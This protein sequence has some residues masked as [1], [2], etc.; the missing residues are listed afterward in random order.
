MAMP[1]R[2]SRVSGVPGVLGSVAASLS[3]VMT[4]EKPRAASRERSLKAKVRVTSFSTMDSLMR[5]PLSRPPWAGSSRMTVRLKG[6]GGAGLG[7]GCA[8]A[9]LP[10][11]GAAG[12]GAGLVWAGL[13]WARHEM[14]ASASR[15][16]ADFA[17]AEVAG[18][19]AAIPVGLIVTGLMRAGGLEGWRR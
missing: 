7:A 12:V 8:G 15:R 9:V 14:D 4:T 1:A 5:E 2:S 17:R 13:F 18:F 3:R 10:V 6:L 11:A 16:A 19:K